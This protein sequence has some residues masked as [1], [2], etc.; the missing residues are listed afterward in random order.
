MEPIC[1]KCGGTLQYV[2]EATEYHSIA[3]I[4]PDGYVDLASLEDT[5]LHDEFKL[6]C[7]GCGAAMS[8]KEFYS[9]TSKKPSKSAKSKSKKPPK[10]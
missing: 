5:I 2:Q 10:S 7:E 6:L 8:L 4:S 1:P 9:L 3:D